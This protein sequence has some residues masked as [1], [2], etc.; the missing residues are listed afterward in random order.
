VNKFAVIDFETTGLSPGQGARPT[1]IAVVIIDN[2]K[3]VDRYQSL[4][5]ADVPIPYQIQLKTG[6]TD[7]MVRKAPS[8]GSVMK[9]AS[10]F[11]GKLPLVAH[12]ATFDC[13]FWDIELQSLRQRRQQ[14]FICSL[15]LS[16][17][18]FSD[19]PNHQ[20][21]TLV[22]TLGLP[23]TGAYHRALADAEATAYLLIRIQQEI[24]RRFRPPTVSHGLL[25]A[26]QAASASQL[27][28]CIENYREAK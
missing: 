5:N 12:N 19:A 15:L 6:I 24:T 13:K 25:L 28:S 3:I 22:R 11:V 4:M 21:E 23:A 14:E 16:R 26:V 18:L 27:K 8:V 10:S 9:A 17:R 1:E 2:G 7:A 20:L